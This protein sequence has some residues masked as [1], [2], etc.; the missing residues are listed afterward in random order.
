MTPNMIRLTVLLIALLTPLAPA[1]AGWSGGIG[2]LG[3]SYSDEYQFY[4]PHRSMARNWVEI[5]AETRGLDFGRFSTQSRGE[6]RNQGYEYNWARSDATTDD[7]IATGQH[8]GLAAQVARGEVNL[9]IVFIGGNDFINAMKTADPAAA[10]QQVGPRAEAN[11]ER[12]VATILKAHADVRLVIITVPDIRDLPEFRVPLH[13]GRLPLADANAATATIRRYNARIRSLAAREPRVAVLDFDLVTRLSELIY[14]ES[15]PVA[16]QPIVRSDP[17]DDPRHLFLGD[18]RHLGTV[19]QGLLAELLDVT[20]DGKLAAGVPPLSEREVLEYAESRYRAAAKLTV[21]PADGGSDPPDP[22][23]QRDEAGRTAVDDPAPCCWSGIVSDGS[24]ALESEGGS[25]PGTLQAM[26][27]GVDLS[28]AAAISGVSALGAGPAGGDGQAD[29]PSGLALARPY[30]R[31]RIPVIFVHGL[32]SSPKSWVPMIEALEADPELRESYQFW[33][34]GYATGA[35]LLYSAQLLRRDLRAARRRFDPAGA[36]PAFDRMVL[37]GHSMGGLLA[38]MMAQDSRSHLWELRSPRP[39]EQLVG[40]SEDCDLLRRLVFFE[41]QPEVRRLILIATPHRGSRLDR[42]FVHGVGARLCRIPDPLEQVHRRL[43]VSNGPE[44]FT[45]AF[46]WRLPSSIDQL[47]WG[48]PELQALVALGIEPGVRYHSIIAD[49]RDP[50]LAGGTDGVVP[51]ASAHLDGAS[52]ELLVNGGHLCQADPL[53]IREVGRILAE[54]LRLPVTTRAGGV[55]RR[56][57]HKGGLISSIGN[58]ACA[59][60]D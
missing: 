15:V 16:G 10:F 31:G 58:P 54:H 43:L 55:S 46:R 7:L 49:L 9:A 19:G 14:P 51:Y 26:R 32:G 23:G 5:L 22:S 52:S 25:G 20:I 45:P 60:T 2:V 17:S 47:A 8:T 53:V 4:P 50:P 29:R 24:V 33:T 42:G 40:P 39:F 11:L 1:S 36:D 13:A 44:F 38:K 59:E 57:R 18:F 41:S 6:P 3:D 48:H 12:A 34:F 21:G 35:P 28:T 56:P 37:I 30:C 27:P